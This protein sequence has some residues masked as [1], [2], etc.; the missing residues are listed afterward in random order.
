MGDKYRLVAIECGPEH[1][2]FSFSKGPGRMLPFSIDG[3]C[4]F[5]STLT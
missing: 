5:S 2:G 3:K 4:G 1:V